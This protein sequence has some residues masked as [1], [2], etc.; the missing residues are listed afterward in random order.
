[1]PESQ[2]TRRWIGVFGGSF[3]P[4]HQGHLSLVQWAIAELHLDDLVLVPAWRSW[5]KGHPG[6]SASDRLSML[7]L[8]LDELVGRDPSLQGRLTINTLEIQA[9]SPGYSVDTLAA[10]RH[11]LGDQV[12]LVLLMGSDQLHNL[13]SWSRYENLLTLAHIGVTQREHIALRSFPPAVEALV[14]RHGTQR[15]PDAASGSLCFFRMPG[16]PISSTRLRQDLAARRPVDALIPQSVLHYIHQ[17]SLYSEG[18]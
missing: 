18:D 5:Q 11:T 2:Q 8:A 6:A 10:L 14:Q 4:V 7:G 9:Q 3:D 12:A 17:H 13:A 15:L 16:Q 1:L